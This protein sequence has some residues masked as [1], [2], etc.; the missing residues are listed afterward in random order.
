MEGVDLAAL[1]L[2]D[3]SRTLLLRVSGV[4]MQGAGIVDGDLL[5]VDCGLE[6]RIGQVVVA[7]IE[8]GFTVKRLVAGP[9]GPVLAAAHPDYPPLPLPDGADHQLLGVARWVIRRC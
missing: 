1:L 9:D 2:R 6:P 8:G 7:R 5:L 3:P 4:S